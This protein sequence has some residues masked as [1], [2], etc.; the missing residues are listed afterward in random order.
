MR[1]TPLT[2]AGAK[3]MRHEPTEAER[4][5]WSYLKGRDGGLT[6]T[7]PMLSRFADIKALLA[8]DENEDA[9]KR[10]RAA[11][12]IGRFIGN[13]AFMKVIEKRSGRKPK[14]GS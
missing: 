5:L 2:Y 7:G 14:V 4:R 12:S 1:P 10:L 11:E 9:L 8:E 6:D 3:R 13:A